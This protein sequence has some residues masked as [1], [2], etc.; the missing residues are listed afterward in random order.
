MSDSYTPQ[1]MNTRS[2][3][4][5][6]L[7]AELVHELDDAVEE[8]PA[9]VARPMSVNANEPDCSSRRP[10]K[11]GSGTPSTARP[12]AEARAHEAARAGLVEER[13]ARRVE[14]GHELL[15]E[16]ARVALVVGVLRRRSGESVNTTMRRGSPGGG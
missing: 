13:E 15:G 9:A 11:P 1:L 10:Q 6:R 12:R 7:G 5:L 16:V 2:L 3:I 8:R 4:G 14:V